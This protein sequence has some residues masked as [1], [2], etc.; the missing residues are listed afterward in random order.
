MNKLVAC[1]LACGL[2]LGGTVHAQEIVI[3]LGTLA[4]EG[5]PWHVLLKETAQRWS[6]LSGGQVK[7]RVFA[8]GTLGDEGDMIKKMRIGELQA[9]ALSTVGLRDITPEPSAMDLP[10]LATTPGEVDYL[11]EKFGPRLDPIL[12]RKGFVVLNWSD[13]GFTRFFTTRPRPTLAEMRKARL[14]AWAGDPAAVEAWKRGGFHPVVLSSTDILP[15][16]QTGMIDA[17]PYPPTV[18]LTGRL[19]TRAR[20]MS[21]L[22]WSPLT[23]ALVVEKRAWERVPAGLRP[24]MIEVARDVGRR[25]GE[26]SQKMEDESIAKMRSLGLQVVAVTDRPE[27]DRMIQ[28]VYQYIRGNV[29][30]AWAF[31]EVQRLMQEHHRKKRDTAAR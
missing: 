3:K 29:V 26:I 17:V 19:Y 31:D 6:E 23:G 20:Y 9:A 11:I 10:L 18:A 5:S 28:Q 22:V 14:F 7:L 1:A 21:D 8:G 13:V 16:L 12:A 2:L 30:P 25:T 15:A 24:R 4:P 27:W